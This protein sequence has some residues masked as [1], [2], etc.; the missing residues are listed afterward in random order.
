MFSAAQNHKPQKNLTRWSNND[1]TCVCENR[2][3]AQL[4]QQVLIDSS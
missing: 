2:W 3:L 4:S 1:A